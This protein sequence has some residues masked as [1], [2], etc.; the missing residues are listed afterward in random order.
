MEGKMLYGVIWEMVI[1]EDL[2]SEEDVKRRIGLACAAFGGFGKMW[3]EKSI[4]IAT[5]MKL[6]Y[7]LV[8]P[9]LLYGS[10]CW[11]LRKEDERRLLVAEMSWLRRIIGRSRREKVRN[12]Q[13]REELGAEETVVQKI[14]KRR[15]TTVIWTGG[16]AGGE[17]I[18]KCNFTW[19]C[20]GKE[21]QR[22]TEE[23]LDG[24][25]HGRPE[26]EEHRLDQ[27]W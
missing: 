17:K 15:Q 27:D 11:S 13:I 14:K 22:E 1:E 6:Y 4:S 8:V 21:K 24:Q 25:C 18:T 26:R 2:F 16:K 19:T 20:R 10:E 7:T 9:V 5:K 3:I 12:E 23:D